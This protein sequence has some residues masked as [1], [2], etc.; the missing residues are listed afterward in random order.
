MY[1]CYKIKLSSDFPRFQG[2]YISDKFQPDNTKQLFLDYVRLK[3]WF[4]PVIC[5]YWRYLSLRIAKTMNDS[6]IPHPYPFEI[7]YGWHWWCG[8][9]GEWCKCVWKC[10]VR[11]FI[12]FSLFLQVLPR[13]KAFAPWH[14]FLKVAVILG[15]AIGLELYIHKTS[16]YKWFLTAPLGFL[17]AL[18]GKTFFGS[19]EIAVLVGSH[20]NSRDHL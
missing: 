8:R 20:F 14:Y 1:C 18:I 7:I 2:Y 9:I 17:F 4:Y 13:A 16:S 6:S 12:Y 15:L 5:G 11:V 3:Q 19:L 10:K